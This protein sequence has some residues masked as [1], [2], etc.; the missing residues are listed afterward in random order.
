V[1]CPEKTLGEGHAKKRRRNLM[2][3]WLV[4]ASGCVF[5]VVAMQYRLPAKSP[6]GTNQNRSAPASQKHDSKANHES[7]KRVVVNRETLRE[8]AAS[9]YNSRSRRIEKMFELLEPTELNIAL[10]KQAYTRMITDVA[11]EFGMTEIE[12]ESAWRKYGKSQQH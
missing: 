6:G 9:E 2:P 3:V 11:K 1:E 5:A 10:H 8:A 4:I 7:P 12:L